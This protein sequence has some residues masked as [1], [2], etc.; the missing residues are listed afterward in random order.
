MPNDVACLQPQLALFRQDKS[1]REQHK[2]SYLIVR[3]PCATLILRSTSLFA[4]GLVHLSPPPHPSSRP[5]SDLSGC[6]SRSE[7]R[8]PFVFSAYAP[9]RSGINQLVAGKVTFGHSPPTHDSPGPR[10]PLTAIGSARQH[11]HI[12]RHPISSEPSN[13]PVRMSRFLFC[14]FLRQAGS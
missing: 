8:G 11:T 10:P 1:P 14:R 7:V 13:M 3:L 4:F 6:I 12:L 5:V 2:T 9:A